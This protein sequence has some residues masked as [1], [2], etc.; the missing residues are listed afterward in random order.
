MPFIIDGHNLIA[1]LPDIDLEDPED[2]AKLVELVQAFAAR[3]GK[4]V[5]LYFDRRS[6]GS[7]D[8]P[9]RGGVHVHFVPASRTADKAILRHLTNLGSQAQNW[10]VVS[11]DREIMHAARRAGAQTISS[12]TFGRTLHDTVDPPD[13]EGAK[14]EMEP[15]REEVEYWLRI[16]SQDRDQ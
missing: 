16:F 3:A 4:Q 9:S 5:Y 10:T 7:K 11:S 14:P 6:P 12:Q 13:Q 1:S 2:E 15:T 8:P